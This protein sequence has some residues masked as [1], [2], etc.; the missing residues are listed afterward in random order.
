MNEII[1]LNE[2]NIKEMNILSLSFIGDAVH[3]LFVREKILKS[4]NLLAGDYHNKCVKYCNAG[5]QAEMFDKL[6]DELTEQEQ[7]IAKR[8]RNAKSHKAKNS[9]IENYKKATAF[10]AVIGYLF[11]LKR[12]DRLNQILEKTFKIKQNKGDNK[13]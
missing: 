13:C 11:L 4:N 2:L 6:F 12:T 9:S 10:E 3:T 8:A 7:E 1:E 5:A